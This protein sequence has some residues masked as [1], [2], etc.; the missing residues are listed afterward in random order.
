[1]SWE[2]DT[3]PL[4]FHRWMKEELERDSARLVHFRIR[5]ES[6][7]RDWSPRSFFR[8]PSLC[9]SCCLGFLTAMYF[10]AVF[11]IAKNA[12]RDGM[13]PKTEKQRVERSFI[14]VTLR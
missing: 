14:P 5:I 12:L 7:M 6:G 1:M 10:F 3:Q 13:R 9:F 8:E 11:T 4:P 2:D